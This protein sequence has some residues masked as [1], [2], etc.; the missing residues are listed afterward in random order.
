MKQI[1]IRWE[2]GR[3]HQTVEHAT[4]DTN[5]TPT[6]W[7]A[8]YID[9]PNGSADPPLAAHLCPTCHDKARRFIA[10]AELYPEE[11][12]PIGPVLADGV[13]H[14]QV[15]YWN[16]HGFAVPLSALPTGTGAQIRFLS[17]HRPL[18]AT[19]ELVEEPF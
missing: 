3:C 10:G 11:G 1:V 6:G 15:G 18:F 9:H 4:A 12:L 5:W 2:C 7:R 17:E 8:L 14:E 16:E 13:R 19:G